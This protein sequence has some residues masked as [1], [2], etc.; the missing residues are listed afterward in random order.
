MCLKRHEEWGGNLKSKALGSKYT[1]RWRHIKSLSLHYERCVRD[2]VVWTWAQFAGFIRLLSP[3]VLQSTQGSPDHLLNWKRKPENGLHWLP[4]Y[5][6]ELSLAWLENR[7]NITCKLTLLL[8]AN[9]L[10][11]MVV[12]TKMAVVKRGKVAALWKPYE[13]LDWWD[14]GTECGEWMTRSSSL[15]RC[16]SLCMPLLLELAGCGFYLKWQ[17][18]WISETVE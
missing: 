8:C 1:D 18:F 17:A 12:G 15:A 10:E 14:L 2:G 11:P 16:C 13:L 4:P 6:L 7:I 5:T 3:P 9:L